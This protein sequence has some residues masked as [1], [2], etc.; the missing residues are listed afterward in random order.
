MKSLILSAFTASAMLLGSPALAQ[1]KYDP[2]A[3]DTEVKVGNFVPYSG[4]ASAYGIVGQTLAAYA[5]MVNEK[6]GING[7]KIN[8]VSYDDAY[9]PP[10]AVEQTRKLVESDEVLFMYQTLGT[11]SNSAI[12][13]YMNSR[14]VPQLMVSSG[15]TKFGDHKEYPWTMPFN[16]PYQAEGRIYAAYILKNHPNAKIAVLYPNDDYGKD[17]YKGIRDGLG[18]KTSMIVKDLTYETSDPTIDSQMVALKGSGADM[19]LNLTTPKFAAMAIRKLGELKWKPV[20]ILNN[21]SASTGAVIKP[22]GYDNAQDAIT[23]T[24]VKDPTDP[25][26]K[27]DPAIKE[28]EAFVDKYMTG[29]DKTNSLILYAYAA[30]QVMEQIVK[31][32]GDNLTRANIMKQAEN[33]KDLKIGA[34]MN[35]IVM[36]TSPTDHY[37]IEQMQLMRFKGERWEMFG[38]LLEGKLTD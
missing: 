27:N 8:L 25:Q 24:Y 32:A 34:L 17:I 36:N 21:V 23:A 20:H 37:P 3:S 19:F 38:E 18:A 6:G 26:F 16:S 28:W 4:P 2:G 14:K 9:S 29:G 33:L 15:G 13:K 31:Q 10:K 22:A 7:R 1:K 35:G 5:K 30:A 11:P 12:L